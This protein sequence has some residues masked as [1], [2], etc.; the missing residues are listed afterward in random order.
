MPIIPKFIIRWVA[1]RY[2]AG[3]DIADAIKV[4]KR[5]SSENACFTVDVLGEEIS[6]IEEVSF[7]EEEY[8]NL[9]DQIINHN[10]DA[11]ISLK[12]TAFGLL[13]DESEALKKIEKIAR[14][15]AKHGMFV[16]LDMEDHRVTQQTI[17]LVF[18][19]HQSGLYN[20]GTVLQA[21]LFRTEKDIVKIQEKL[22]GKSDIRICKGIYLESSD[23]AH[24]SYQDI[25]DATNSSIDLLL[26]CR[27]Y[28]AIASHDIPVI[29]H[30]LKALS[31]RGFI[32]EN[33]ELDEVELDSINWGKGKGPGYEFQMLLGVRGDIR[34][35]L[36]SQGHRTRIYL[37]YGKHWYEYSMRRL[38]EN[39]DV[40]W[41]V[42][43]SIVMPWT[44]RR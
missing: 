1:K 44:N 34:R 24:T 10:L 26:D 19:L 28:T 13:I 2:V 29:E 35:K 17:D 41:H 20:V 6:S 38:R 42:A 36:S 7:F 14:K 27:A 15:A 5:L 22:A 31:S 39:P 23:I 25:V 8:S 32:K 37:P 21:R 12:P 33:L 4:M 3:H 18:S 9:I 30:S 11:N 16:R 43:K 40:A